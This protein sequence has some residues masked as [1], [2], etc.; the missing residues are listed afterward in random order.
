MFIWCMLVVAGASAPIA[1]SVFLLYSSKEGD[2][3]LIPFPTLMKHLLH[4][5]CVLWM[6]YLF[7]ELEW[8]IICSNYLE[9]IAVT[10]L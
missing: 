9:F 10:G 2:L 7:I 5:K 8:Q 6:V 3:G 4:I 1:L